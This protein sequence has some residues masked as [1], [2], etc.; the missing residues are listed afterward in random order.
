M[1][2]TLSKFRMR[3][4][5]EE[6]GRKTEKGGP[7][8]SQIAARWEAGWRDG[9]F[10]GESALVLVSVKGVGCGCRDRLSEWTVNA[11]SGWILCGCQVRQE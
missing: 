4:E 10:R 3:K 1:S 6:E 9:G 2:L 5:G 7:G 8:R 11:G